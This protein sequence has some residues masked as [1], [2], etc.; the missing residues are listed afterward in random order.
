SNGRS[1]RTCAARA[2]GCTERRYCLGGRPPPGLGEVPPPSSEKANVVATTPPA[3]SPASS[4][5]RPLERRR[6]S[7]EA[8]A[9]V[10]SVTVSPSHGYPSPRLVSTDDTDT[11]SPSVLGPR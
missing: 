3:P 1:S 8:M 4:R 11:S 5:L 6:T 2:S 7:I 9:S 10:G